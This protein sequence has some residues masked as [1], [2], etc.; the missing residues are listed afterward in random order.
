MP[1]PVDEYGPQPGTEGA[2]L[3]GTDVTWHE[4]LELT[5]R[6]QGTKRTSEP[7]GFTVSVALS[8]LADPVFDA[9]GT[10]TTTLDG[11]TYT[12]PQNGT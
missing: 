4:D 1:Q 3:V 12:Q 8:A 5:G 9:R 6:H 10:L 11:H 7:E 2:A